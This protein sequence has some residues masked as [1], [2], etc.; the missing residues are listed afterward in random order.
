MSFAPGEAG[1]LRRDSAF[2]YTAD[3]SVEAIASR[4]LNT[5]RVFISSISTAGG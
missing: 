3:N 2:E 4:C 1:N 5:L